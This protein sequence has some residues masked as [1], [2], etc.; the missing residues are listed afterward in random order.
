[1]LF[2]SGKKQWPKDAL[3]DDPEFRRNVEYLYGTGDFVV[4]STLHNG[5]C[6]RFTLDVT[7][8]MAASGKAPERVAPCFTE[9]FDGD[10]QVSFS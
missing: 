8:A 4:A 2:R 1:M 3:A 7:E 6:A 9:F 10:L 5:L